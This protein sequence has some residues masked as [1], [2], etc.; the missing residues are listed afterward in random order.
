MLEPDPLPRF[1]TEVVEKAER[2]IGI[3]PERAALLRELCTTCFDAGLT[4]ALVK[5]NGGVLPERFK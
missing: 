3:T 2:T 5:A 1:I 4:L